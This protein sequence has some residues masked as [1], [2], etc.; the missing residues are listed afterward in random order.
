[1]KL[2]EL[3]DRLEEIE[4]NTSFDPDV[5]ILIGG[6]SAQATG[7]EYFPESPVNYEAVR[8]R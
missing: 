6:V 7:I 3:I 5:F 2:S 1:M 4:E 8:I